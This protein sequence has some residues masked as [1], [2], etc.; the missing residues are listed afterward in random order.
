M[1]KAAIFDMDGTLVDSLGFWEIY[2]EKIGKDFLGVSDF[3]CDYRRFRSPW[4][5]Q[6][7]Y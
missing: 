1:I 6:R 2:W 7:L 4:G 5:L 3:R